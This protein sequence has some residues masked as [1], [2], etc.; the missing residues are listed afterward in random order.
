MNK[1]EGYSSTSN[2]FEDLRLSLSYL[3]VGGG[4]FTV[5]ISMRNLKKT[6]RD[7]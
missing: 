6:R 5:S 4:F 7:E 3:L 2:I 1:A